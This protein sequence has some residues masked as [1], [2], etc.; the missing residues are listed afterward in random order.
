[1]RIGDLCRIGELDRCCR[2]GD[3]I[4]DIDRLTG[5]SFDHTH[6]PDPCCSVERSFAWSRTYERETSRSRIS[7][8]NSRCQNIW[9]CVGHRHGKRNEV[10]DVD[11][12][13]SRCFFYLQISRRFERFQSL[14]VA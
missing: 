8:F 2:A 14:V 10:A 6:I 5:S 1:M 11:G 12:R 4:R 9:I 7:N 13:S 3:L